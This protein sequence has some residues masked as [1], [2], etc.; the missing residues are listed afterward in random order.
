MKVVKLEY[1]SYLIADR[2]EGQKW[3]CITSVGYL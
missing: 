2:K 1:H 3:Y